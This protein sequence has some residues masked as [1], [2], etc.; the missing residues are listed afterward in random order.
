M[1]KSLLSFALLAAMAGAAQA[2]DVQIYGIVDAGLQADHGGVNGNTNKLSSGIESPSRIGFKGT[3]DLGNGLTGFFVLENGFSTDTGNITGSQNQIFGRQSYVGVSNSFGS[4]TLGRQYTD[5]YTSVREIAD[6]FQGGLAGN[7]FNVF[8][9]GGKRANNSVRIASAN[10][11]GVSGDVMYSLGEVAGSNTASRTMSG[12]LGYAQGPLA[13][14]VAYL[15]TNDATDTLSLH[16]TALSA[17]Y[18]FNV[19]KAHFGYARNT[20]AN[21]LIDTRDF[22]IGTSVP[23]AQNV[24]FMASY[25]K[26]DDRSAFDADARQ[27]GVGL[28]YTLSKRTNLY[29]SYAHMTNKNDAG[30][31]VGNATDVGTGTTGF[32]VGMRHQ[33]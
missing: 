20:G 24:K 31:T 33:F 23:V 18:D 8:Y 25:V 29:T 7:V 3:E 6:P 11:G 19:A 2:G 21:G 15:T 4:V 28:D 26:R 5:I 1:K 17:S 10:Y 27:I 22:L 14:R 9:D 32:N 16:A 12:S 30:Y 13:T